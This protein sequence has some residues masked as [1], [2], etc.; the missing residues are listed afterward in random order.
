MNEKARAPRTTEKSRQGPP[1]GAVAFLIAGT[2]ALVFFAADVIL[3]IYYY[4]NTSGADL[5]WLLALVD[6][7]LVLAVL[8]LAGKRV[9]RILVSMKLAVGLLF[10]PAILSIIGTILPNKTQVVESGWINNPLYDFYNAIGLFDMYY[11]R[12]F[13]FLLFLLTAN[14]TWCIYKRMHVTIKNAVHPK[15]DVRPSFI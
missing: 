8:S 9:S 1:Q 5:R 14:L 12:W 15:V 2:L 3:S 11:S 6:L 13:L 4:R 7:A 10:V